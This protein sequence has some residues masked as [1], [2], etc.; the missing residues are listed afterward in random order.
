MTEG[1]VPDW[2]DRL[3]WR[4]AHGSIMASEILRGDEGTDLVV[5]L[6]TAPSRPTKADTVALF[7]ARSGGGVAP[8]LVAVTYQTPGT[9]TRLTL[10]GLS[11]DDEP[12]HDL[13]PRIAEQLIADALTARSPVALHT[14]V[15]RRLQAVSSGIASGLRNEGLLA[16][17]VL[18]GQAAEATWSDLCT[19]STPLLR[20]RG[21]GL[22]DRLGYSVEA[23][24]DGTVLREASNGHRRAAVVLLSE[25][26][27]FENPLSRLNQDN[28][29]Q[30]GLAVAR[31]ENVSWVVVI[32]G[33]LM[34]LYPVSPDVGVGRKG[35]TQTFVELD[36]ALLS[37]AE[38]GYLTLLF[39][40]ASLAPAGDL[41]RLLSESSRYAVGLSERL[42]DRI[43]D[44][45]VTILALAVADKRSVAAQPV[46]QRKE[47]LSEAYHQSMIILFRLLF[48]AYAEDRG[49]LPYD[50][51][52]RYR[53]H[54][55]KTVAKD[56]LDR[57]DQ[58][59]DP[60]ST[61]LWD[62]L[63]QVWK[64]VDTGDLGGW[65]IPAY[66]GGLF[67][68]D[69]GKNPSGA[70]TYDLGLT[71]D[72]VGPVL[73]GLLIDRDT[74]GDQG[75][76][77]FRSLS[78]REFGTIYEGLL[79]SG[80][81]ITDI[82]LAVDI[83][84]NYVPATGND[85]VEV[86]AGGVYF[87]SQS[88]SRKATGSYFT[89]PFAVEHLLDSALEPALDRHLETV[90]LLIDAGTT[91][92]AAE[93]LFD[94]RVADL[95]MG[96]AHFL[97]AAIDRIEARFSAFLVDNPLPEVAQELH[98]LRAVAAQQLDL[99]PA[100]SGIDDG[101]LLRRQIARRC[102]YGSDV[103][104]IAVEL[105]RL[106]IWIHT[107]VPGLPLSFLNHGLV[108]GNSLTGIGTINEIGEALQ[109]AER[110]ELKK[111]DAAQLSGLDSVIESFMDRA[112]ESLTALGSL[113]DAS[114]QDVALAGSLQAQLEGDL[115]PL[116][117]LCDLVAAERMTR[118]LGNVSEKTVG[119]NARGQQ[120]TTRKT[121]PHPDR[122]LL[123]ANPALFTATDAE[124][125]ES[126]ILE[127]AHLGK[128]QVL[129]QSVNANH[130]PVQFP[131]VFRRARPGFDCILGNPPW[132]KMHVEEHAWWGLRFPGLRSMTQQDK[133]DTL[134]RLRVERPDLQAEF[135]HE[136]MTVGLAAEGIAKGPFPGIGA[137]HLDLFSAFC[138]RFLNE[139]RSGGFVG[140]VLPRGALAGSATIE[141]R[142]EV[143]RG[144]SFR[145]LTLLVNNR[146][147]MFDV[148]HPQY[149]VA[150]ATIERGSA[151]KGVFLRGPYNS[152]NA[153]NAGMNRGDTDISYFT[154]DEVMAW[155]EGAAFPLL[156]S[157]GSGP[158]F[159]AMQKSPVLGAAVGDWQF[160]PVQGD[161]NATKAKPFFDFA[162]SS[163]APTHNLPI[164]TGRSFGNW[165]PNGEELY[166]FADQDGIVQ[167][168][169]TK[170][171][172]QVTHKAS[173]F[174]GQPG[175]W[176]AD[177]D[178]LPLRHPRI[179]FRDVTRATDTRTAICVLVPGGVGLVHQAPYLFQVAGTAKN[180]AY[181]LG[182]MSSRIFDWF[183]RRYVE[184]HLT[185]EL[186]NAFPVP[187][188]DSKT[189][190]RLGLDGQPENSPVNYQALAD[191][192]IEIAGRLAAIDDRYRTWAN[193]VGVPVGSVTSAVEKAALI[194]EL[195]A[196]AALLY[197][198]TASHVT[199]LF[200][201]FHVG[202]DAT[203]H[204]AAVLVHYRTWA[205]SLGIEAETEA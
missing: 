105:A 175:T 130:M 194:E 45:V 129:A 47:A 182:V 72:V 36:L 17:H 166:A 113:V 39:S 112:H 82:D 43:Y 58:I 196:C 79:E 71:N 44:K 38:A 41:T 84:N 2:D 26:E 192:V 27:S 67:T 24:P 157:P 179:A 104:E 66:N 103:N 106:G 140:V 3:P 172:K 111:K 6:A 80:L 97:V 25:S 74:N 138:W 7:R 55:L 183:A 59:H 15:R 30:H 94:F 162:L 96:S 76:V 57:P 68:R 131:E 188:I 60:N 40:P 195:D 29:I 161:L 152:M 16:S 158:V 198:L 110:R 101:A 28:A 146:Q 22:L 165:D 154:P 117:A 114:I 73:R 141:W 1:L 205:G 107:F 178:T 187:R 128:A 18:Q 190:H 48:V 143:L 88:G 46:E 115:A 69:P 116:A 199:E 61:T 5:V 174:C 56:L 65:G 125:L 23:V 98:G 123:S 12:V 100:E 33:S 197:G 62:D 201:T 184:L 91:R 204:T 13:D 151:D 126:A 168:L 11:D 37:P 155:G 134:A 133:N 34:R 122:V 63:T 120:V 189:R 171:A 135:E 14:E 136:V 50:S 10:M 90:R 142:K 159:A 52:E 149:T 93:T 89:K 53:Q 150:L 193:D 9:A 118:H 108:Y 144:S 70:A 121:V 49:L 200:A 119:Y 124:A 31:R 42:R 54:A 20:E 35:Q 203:A 92:T 156:P 145:D 51:S 176:A 132:E 109:D 19:A 32:G 167:M 163:P 202:W 77:D 83:K 185:F 8:L 137:A 160:R 4:K 78:V 95:S 191:R 81:D 102:I 186:L 164:W 180:E 170:R 148:V 64:V 86:E 75:P 127:H 181:L 21:T 173:A 87:H 99:N 139:V 177:P 153:Y 147:W 169:Q 85:E